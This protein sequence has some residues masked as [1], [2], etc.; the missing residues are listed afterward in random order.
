MTSWE[1]TCTVCKYATPLLNNAQD[2]ANETRHHLK[3]HG[4]LTP[5]RPPKTTTYNAPEAQMQRARDAQILRV[6]RDK[7]L[8][9]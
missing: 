1:Y 2:H 4:F 3:V 8:L 9:K 5:N 6:A 7:G